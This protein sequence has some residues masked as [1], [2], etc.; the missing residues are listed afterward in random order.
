MATQKVSRDKLLERAAQ[1]DQVPEE[2]LSP[3]QLKRRRDRLKKRKERTKQQ[4][5][6]TAS[7][8]ATRQEFWNG[9]RSALSSNELTAMQA[10]HERVHDLLD[11]MELCGHENEGL[12]FVSVEETT[13]DV[14]ESVRQHGV[15]HLG[16]IV[17]N[18]IP[19]DWSEQQ[20]WRDAA[21]LEKLEGENLQTK[22]FVKFGLLTALPD[23]QAVQ[24]L[25]EKGGWT[26]QHAAALV[27]Y[28]DHRDQVKYR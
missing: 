15:A 25:T 13:A 26:W 17:K 7:I 12:D 27:G 4:H 16:S 8:A 22:Q 23:W 20:F 24:F 6:K 10:Q 2:V 18:D 14:V 9:N 5:E 1:E 3:E 21:L 28:H 11:W 19:P